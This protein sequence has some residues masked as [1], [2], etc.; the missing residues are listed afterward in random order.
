MFSQKKTGA[1]LSYMNIIVKNAVTFMYTPFL[2]KFIGQSDYGL[3]QMTNSIITSLSLLSLGFSSS[4]VHFYIKYKSNNEYENIK[5]LNGMY[6]VLFCFISLV[7]IC[8]GSV[9]TL[10][11]DN[12]FNLKQSQVNLMKKLMGI[13]ILNVA[14]SFPSSV[15]DS[16][17]IVNQKF[18]YQQGRQLLQTILV[19]LIAVPMIMLGSGVL[20]IGIT[21][22]IVTTL[23]LCINANFCIRNLKMKFKFK[24]KKFTMVKEI[25]AFSFF[26]FLNQI[27]DLINNSGPNFILGIFEG[28][29]KVATFSIA[30]QIKNL[31]FMLSI[32]LSDVF[33]PKVNELVSQKKETKVLTELMIRIGRIQMVVL[34]FIFGG[35]IV[36]GQYFIHLWAGDR[37]MLAYWLVLGMVL[38][39]I[40][41]LS[42]N[43][44]IEIQ[45]AMNMHAFRSIVL[46]IFAAINIVLTAEGTK[47]FGLLGASSGYVIGMIFANGCLMNWYYHYKMDLDIVLYLK[48]TISVVIPFF[49]SIV[50]ML[51]CQ[52]F[53]PVSSTLLFLLYGIVYVF[54]FLIIYLSF[55][56]NNY[57]KQLI[58]GKFYN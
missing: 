14:L 11:A 51:F 21:Q 12:I 44:G 2:L 41:P 50:L 27:V 53:I 43:I 3:F 30:I 24:N 52:L 57:E 20:A 29:D 10:N 36:D 18:I 9:L 23:F 46:L 16:N 5:K 48:Q 54:L 8:I 17:I 34:L 25:L 56:A 45:R 31:F 26:V 4:Y 7:A 58:F 47:Y 35:F 37:N 1:F 28:A 33:I 42:Q 49:V 32:S 38:P 22:T 6:L 55:V 39:S 15:F 40:G 13:M 19:P